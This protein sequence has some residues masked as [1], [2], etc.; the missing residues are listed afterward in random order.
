MSRNMKMPERIREFFQEQGRIGAK[1][2]HS[3]LTPERRKEIARKAAKA[4][5]A[6][7]VEESKIKK[8]T[9]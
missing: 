2:R 4:R 3:N 8:G 9:K 7:R 6:D 1:K 5:W